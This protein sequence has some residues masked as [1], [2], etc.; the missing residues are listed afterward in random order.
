MKMLDRLFDIQNLLAAGALLVAIQ[1]MLLSTSPAAAE[2]GPEQVA[3]LL[4][5]ARSSSRRRT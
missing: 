1:V 4:E 2:V 5:T 3:R